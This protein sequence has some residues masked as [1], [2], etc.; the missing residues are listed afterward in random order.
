MH[1]TEVCY[2]PGVSDVTFYIRCKKYCGIFPPELKHMRQL[3][4]VNLRL[5]KLVDNLSLG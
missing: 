1:V 3:E 4:E 2:R 5:N